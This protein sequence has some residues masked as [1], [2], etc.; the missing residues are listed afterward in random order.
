MASS[1]SDLNV[2]VRAFANPQAYA[3]YNWPLLASLTSNGYTF[4][5]MYYSGY[6]SWGGTRDDSGTNSGLAMNPGTDSYSNYV[7]IWQSWSQTDT[8]GFTNIIGATSNSIIV[9]FCKSS[10]QD[11]ST[12]WRMTFRF[13]TERLTPSGCNS[14]SIKSSRYGWGYYG[15][16]GYWSKTC[17]VGDR[18]FYVTYHFYRPVYTMDQWPYWYGGDY[19][20]LHFSFDSVG[21]DSTNNAQ[22]LF[23]S[24]SIIY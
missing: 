4:K 18:M 12:T 19:Y 11:F 22:Y 2:Y 9:R 20:D 10:S 14:V 8:G 1:Q 3:D 17:G 5:S 24:A 23:A 13:Y 7:N 15:S 21:Q 16:T 6:P